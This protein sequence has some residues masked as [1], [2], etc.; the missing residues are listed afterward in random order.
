M[1]KMTIT[2]KYT[3]AD[4]FATTV[5]DGVYQQVYDI[6]NNPRIS[7]KACCVDA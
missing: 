2:G 5:E 1:E 7:W 3:K 6:I 4:M